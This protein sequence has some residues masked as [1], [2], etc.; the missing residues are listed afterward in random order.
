MSEQ[1]MRWRVQKLEETQEKIAEDVKK[2][3]ESCDRVDSA[4][5]VLVERV[6]N[7]VDAYRAQ[8]TALWGCAGAL[9]L[10]AVG[11]ILRGLGIVG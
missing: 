1:E 10:L 9:V 2:A 11:V 5:A 7:M 3:R 6:G 8:R 4:H